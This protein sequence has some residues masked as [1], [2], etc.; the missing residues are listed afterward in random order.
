MSIDIEHDPVAG[1]Y[2]VELDGTAAYLDYRQVDDQTRDFTHTYVPKAL[3]G[4]GLAG[5]IVR[6]ALEDSRA[7]GIKV[8]ATCSFVAD[9]IQRDPSFADI[10]AK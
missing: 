1:R 2:Y 9:T 5:K 3:R 7:Q 8:I 6:F 10:V 4:R